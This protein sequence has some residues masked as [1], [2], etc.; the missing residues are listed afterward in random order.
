MAQQVP[1][2]PAAEVTDRQGSSVHEILPDVAYRRLAIVNVVFLGRPG[3]GDRQ[4]VLIDAGVMG[5]SS[6]IESARARGS[7]RVHVLW[8]SCSLM[9]TSIMWVRFRLWPIDGMRRSTPTSW[10]CLISQGDLPI[11]RPIR[12]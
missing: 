11:R 1:V 4:W 8:P 12:R 6:L 9:A 5:T 10:R 2:D 3:A 7:A